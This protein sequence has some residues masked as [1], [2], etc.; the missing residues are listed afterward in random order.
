VPPIGLPLPEVVPVLPGHRVRLRPARPGDVGVVGR[1]GI[2]PHI[3]RFY[4]RERAARRGLTAAEA[5]HVVARIA[6][7]G[8]TQGWMI[9]V[10]DRLAG[11]AR[12][13]AVEPD[14]RRAWYSISFLSR[15]HLGRGLGTEA[16]RLVLTYAFAVLGMHRVSARVLDF[17]AR[18]IA[19]LRGSG[20]AVEGREREWL[21]FED[22]WR[23]ALLLGVLDH[24]F[25]AVVASQPECERLS[26][27][28]RIVREDLIEA[29]SERPARRR[30]VP[31]SPARVL[32]WRRQPATGR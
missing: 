16:T 6:G 32:D 2:D 31:V 21:Y 27:L 1:I 18:A 10:G 28:S 5:R 15:D 25:R 11:M 4:G 24:E 19:L 8:T 12:L 7:H 9:E 22:D 20:F 23:D 13:F 30:R 3:Q 14:E 29:Q 17:N 26:G